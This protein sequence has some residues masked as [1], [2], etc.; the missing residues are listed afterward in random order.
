MPSEH[1]AIMT[2]VINRAIEK[3]DE[4]IAAISNN[5]EKMAGEDDFVL[6]SANGKYFFFMHENVEPLINKI[7]FSKYMEQ[8]VKGM[9]TIQ[10]VNL[11]T[12]LCVYEF[13]AVLGDNVYY[14]HSEIVVKQ[15]QDDKNNVKKTALAWHQ[16]S[17]YIPYQHIPYL[18]CWC[19]LTD[20]T[21][22]NGSISVLPIDRN[23]KADEN[24]HID[25]SDIPR[26]SASVKFPCFHH[27]KDDNSADMVGYFGPD[28]GDKVICPAGS[29]VVFSSLTLHC[30]SSNTSNSFRS[31]YNVQ[32][33]PV[34][35]M[36]EDQQ[37]F[38]HDAKPFVVH[39][40]T[41]DTIKIW[42]Q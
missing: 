13:L 15:G 30:S 40:E 28:P 23:P 3:R 27:R 4:H 1:I 25:W 22:Y 37:S 12:K 24:H 29:I 19:A 39:S 8:I 33:S 2:D 5:S 31:A 32:Y 14:T 36:N 7:I 26:P 42:Q 10:L 16:D 20:M 6:Y 21:I 18:S 9:A 35:L 17:G 11:K 38:R 41:A 34:P